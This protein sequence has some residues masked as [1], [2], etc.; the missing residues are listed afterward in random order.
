LKSFLF[1]VTPTDP[2]VFAAVP[3]MLAVIALLASLL[4][5]LRG[6]TQRPGQPATNRQQLFRNLRSRVPSDRAEDNARPAF[7]IVR[8]LRKRFLDV[9]HQP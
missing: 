6:T 9:R 1:E 8:L 3:V 2:L 4:P 7:R 5:T